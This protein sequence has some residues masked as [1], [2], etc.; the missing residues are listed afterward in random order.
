MIYTIICR[1][2]KYPYDK[3]SKDCSSDNS[4]NDDQANHGH[5]DESNDHNVDF[6]ILRQVLGYAMHIIFSENW[7]LISSCLKL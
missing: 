3:Y 4:N 1:D 6:E 7:S 5:D 2:P